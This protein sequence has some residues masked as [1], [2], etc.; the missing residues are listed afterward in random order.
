VI[1]L[2]GI[3]KS[4]KMGEIDLNVLN[5]ITLEIKRKEFV[6]LM[7]PSGSG[8]ST[9]LNIIG[10]L[11]KSSEGTY[12]LA[13]NY[14]DKMTD[15]E[16]ADIRNTKIGFVFQSFNLIPRIDAVRNVEL[17]LIYAGISSSVRKKKSLEALEQVGL[18]DRALHSPAQMSGGQQQRVAIARALV[19]DPEVIIAD[20]PTGSLDTVNGHEVMELF[21]SLHKENDKTIVLVTHET[22]IANYAQRIV[23]VRDGLIESDTI[24]S[25]E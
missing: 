15:D 24:N 14:V 7:G 19:N 4:Y 8:K 13:G 11:D 10:C 12:Q 18:S 17:P 25:A 3:K 21:T 2:S 1:S 9:L 6:T 16:L 5:G 23:R 20:E 22:E